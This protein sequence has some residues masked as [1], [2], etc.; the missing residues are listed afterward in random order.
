MMTKPQPF[1]MTHVANIALNKQIGLVFL[2]QNAQETSGLS[3]VSRESLNCDQLF[4]GSWMINSFAPYSQRSEDSSEGNSQPW[5]EFEPFDIASGMEC[6]TS[7]DSIE[8]ERLI[9]VINAIDAERVALGDKLWDEAHEPAVSFLKK[10]VV[11]VDECV[12]YTTR[13]VEAIKLCAGMDPNDPESFVECLTSCG[14]EMGMDIMQ[15]FGGMGMHAMGAAGYLMIKNVI[16][17]PM[18]FCQ[19]L[20]GVIRAV[21]EER[22]VEE[23]YASPIVD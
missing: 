22:A 5:E 18:I 2:M 11:Q 19:R 20:L 4:V 9:R 14:E 10:L 1:L 16:T 8:M 21:V 7:V 23:G 17:P 15:G 6:R 12:A 13:R 3:D